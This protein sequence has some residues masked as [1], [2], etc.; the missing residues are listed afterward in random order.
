MVGGWSPLENTSMV[1]PAIG[2]M[3]TIIA[4][5][6]VVNNFIDT[7]FTQQQ[8]EDGLVLCKGNS[9]DLFA[10]FSPGFLAN[11]VTLKMPVFPL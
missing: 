6:S 1:C 8:E 10:G 4:A 11:T 9:N 2:E 3:P 7:I 5:M